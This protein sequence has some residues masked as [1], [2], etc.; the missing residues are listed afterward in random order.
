MRLFPYAICGLG[1]VSK[2]IEC[3]NLHQDK[4]ISYYNWHCFR[5]LN[6]DYSGHPNCYCEWKLRLIKHYKIQVLIICS[7]TN[8]DL[9][10]MT[11]HSPLVITW[12]DCFSS[13]LSA[14]LILWLFSCF[15]AHPRGVWVMGRE[16][17]GEWID[18][19]GYHLYFSPLIMVLVGSEVRKR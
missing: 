2:V 11:L 3:N 9:I 6:L 19:M 10:S 18:Q 15:F 4:S 13:C 17:E 12:L 16:R 1:N 14:F 7:V 8:V 5:F